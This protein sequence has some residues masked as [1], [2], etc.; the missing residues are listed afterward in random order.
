VRRQQ[1][2]DHIRREICCQLGVAACLNDQTQR[3]EQKVNQ[4][5]GI[6]IVDVG[7]QPRLQS[8]HMKILHLSVST[9][10]YPSGPG[11]A[12]N[13]MYPLGILLEL[14][15]MEVVS[16]DNWSLFIRLLHT[17]VQRTEYK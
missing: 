2:R 1:W 8:N 11:L 13:R 7:F 6:R 9:A 14:R 16:G 10:F 3:R 4:F 12:D 15:M 5:R 17:A